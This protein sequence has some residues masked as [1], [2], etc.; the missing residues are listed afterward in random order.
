M[1]ALGGGRSLQQIHALV[2]QVVQLLLGGPE[3]LLLPCLLKS[4]E[5]A[6]MT[7]PA[8]PQNACAIFAADGPPAGSAPSGNDNSLRSSLLQPHTVSL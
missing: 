2:K 6:W 5:V 4:F 8:I 3:A 7:V 1:G